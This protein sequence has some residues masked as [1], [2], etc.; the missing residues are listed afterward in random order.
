MN[1]P[2]HRGE[3]FRRGQGDSHAV[4]QRKDGLHSGLPET[5]LTD[6]NGAVVVLERSGDDL[7]RAGCLAVDENREWNIVTR[8]RNRGRKGLLLESPAPQ[9]DD[10]FPCGQKQGGDLDA[11]LQHSA[12]I[13]SKVEDQ[14]L[15]RGGAE[16]VEFG[17]QLLGGADVEI[18]HANVGYARLQQEGAVHRRRGD[19]R[20]VENE[21]GGQNLARGHDLKRNPRVPGAAQ[22]LDQVRQRQVRH[23]PAVDLDDFIPR[24]QPG[25]AR[26]RAFQR[27]QDDQLAGLDIKNRPEPS[28]FSR[29]LLLKLAELFRVKKSGKGIECRKHAADRAVQNRRVGINGVGVVGFH[30]LIDAAEFF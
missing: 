3:V 12:A 8:I 16:V 11:R 9:A 4:A 19:F 1:G 15:E 14:A 20:R 10:A 28:D 23:A 17:A 29:L 13:A 21:L 26:G 6:Q 22:Q 5:R 7:R 24:S 30:N 25:S 27:L 18:F 2:A